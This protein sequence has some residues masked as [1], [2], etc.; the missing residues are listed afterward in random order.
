MICAAAAACCGSATSDTPSGVP[1]CRLAVRN[2]TGGHP[3]QRPV[4]SNGAAPGWR[5]RGEDL[6]RHPHGPAPLSVSGPPGRRTRPGALPERAGSAASLERPPRIDR[7]RLPVPADPHEPGPR[8]AGAQA[9]K[10]RTRYR[11][12]GVPSG[13]GRHR[14]PQ[15]RPP[16]CPRGR[17]E[18]GR[19]RCD[20]TTLQPEGPG[21]P[22][23]LQTAEVYP[24]GGTGR[25][26]NAE[27]AET[28]WTG[29]PNLVMHETWSDIDGG[30]RLR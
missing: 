27:L 4:P 12:S 10:A 17:A 30:I 22:W 28:T 20:Q 25:F 26:E 11:R 1:G 9:R 19:Y 6:R 18:G 13:N 29:G 7:S 5:V 14:G 15:P 23:I 16:A 24:V 8:P 2:G 3:C 21:S